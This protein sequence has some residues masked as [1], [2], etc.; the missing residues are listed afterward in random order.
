MQFPPPLFLQHSKDETSSGSATSSSRDVYYA[1]R[2][3]ISSPF[4][5]HDRNHTPRVSGVGAL[6]D[7]FL[8]RFASILF[9][10]ILPQ[11]TSGWTNTLFFFATK[12]V[13][14]NARGLFPF[15]SNPFPFLRGVR[16]PEG[17]AEWE[18]FPFVVRMF[19]TL[20]LFPLI[21]FLP[22]KSMDVKE[23]IDF[24]FFW[25]GS[26]FSFFPAIARSSSS[27]LPPDQPLPPIRSI[28]PLLCIDLAP[29]FEQVYKC[30]R[31][32]AFSFPLSSN[33]LI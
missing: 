10:R 6:R 22:A 2:L 28:L 7:T 16:P 13:L 1:F 9:C 8:L 25:F 15:F 4:P 11:R 30:L 31:E 3:T 21:I 33:M 18:F 29:F 32:G 17:R 27:P 23:T 20:P 5:P 12:D 26:N 14:R 24:F 19:V